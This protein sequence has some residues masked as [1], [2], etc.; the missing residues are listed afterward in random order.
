MLVHPPA[1]RVR[2]DGQ[3]A[4]R[5]AGV[6]AAAEDHLEIDCAV[7]IRL[8]AHVFR[9]DVERLRNVADAAAFA[10]PGVV[11]QDRVGIIGVIRRAVGVRVEAIRRSGDPP[12]RDPNSRWP[13]RCAR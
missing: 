5:R 6:V 12:P 7:R 4:L 3:D 8:D 2:I 13:C 11:D 10:P 1:C 9:L